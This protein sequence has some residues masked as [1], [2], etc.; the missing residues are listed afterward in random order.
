MSIWTPT[1]E[2]TVPGEVG[3]TC[4][5]VGGCGEAVGS[6]ERCEA[7]GRWWGGRCRGED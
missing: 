5:C 1:T 6:E 2:W 3:G 4:W 7:E